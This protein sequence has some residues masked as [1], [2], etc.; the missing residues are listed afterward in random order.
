LCRNHAVSTNTNGITTSVTRPRRVSRWRR[1][2]VIPTTE[3]TDVRTEVR[4]VASSSLSASMSDVR[5][6]MMRPDV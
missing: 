4:P 5:R 6:E 1:I 2:T 3:I